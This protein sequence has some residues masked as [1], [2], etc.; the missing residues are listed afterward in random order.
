METRKNTFKLCFA[1]NVTIPAYIDI[2]RFV[3]NV[4]KVPAEKVHSIYKDE[5]D[6]SFYLKFMDDGGFNKF[7]SEIDEVY[8]FQCKNGQCLS[9]K[10][11]MASRLFRYVRIFN[12]SPEIEDKDIAIVMSRFGKIRQ[13]VRER[14]PADLQYAVFSGVRGVHMEVEKEIP[15]NLFIGHFRVR[16]FYEG[17]KNKC[18]FCKA[19]GHLKVNCPKLASLK[20]IDA[21]NENRYNR[22]NTNLRIAMQSMSEKSNPTSSM[23]VLSARKPEPEVRLITQNENCNVAAPERAGLNNNDNVADLTEGNK[24]SIGTPCNQDGNVAI[25]ECTR[26]RGNTDNVVSPENNESSFTGSGQHSNV[27]AT[28]HTRV[29]IGNVDTSGHQRIIYESETDVME[30]E[31]VETNQGKPKTVKRPSGSTSEN[32]GLEREAETGKRKGKKK[33]QLS[34]KTVLPLEAIATRSSSAA[35]TN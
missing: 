3:A 29:G 14:Y 34:E 2:L 5:N 33:K 18:F 1:S 7:H 10:L 35:R 6:Q 21:E 22:V 15:A 27:A 8:Q 16:I 11:E 24:T 28:E 19:E 26:S 32:E 23:T 30:A 4:L 31:E 12:L 20:I 17:S 25:A 9:I 13:Q